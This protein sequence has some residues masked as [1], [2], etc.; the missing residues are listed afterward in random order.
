MNKSNISLSSSRAKNDEYLLKKF[1]EKNPQIKFSGNK[2]Q[3]RSSVSQDKNS[4]LAKAVLSIK[5]MSPKDVALEK[6]KIKNPGIQLNPK[7]SLKKLSSDEIVLNKFKQKNPEIK[8]SLPKV[9]VVKMKLDK[10]QKDMS[11]EDEDSQSDMLKTMYYNPSHPAGYSSPAK[12][13]KYAKRKDPEITFSEVKKWISNERPYYLSKKVYKFP[14]RKVLVR[15]VQHQYQADLMDFVSIKNHNYGFR[16]VLTVIDCFSRKAFAIPLRN[17]KG[18]LVARGLKKA[19]D[20][21][22]VPKKLQTDQGTEFFNKEVKELLDENKIIHFFTR[23][24]LKAQM[25]E[26]FNRTLREKISKHIFASKNLRFYDDIEKFVESYNNS[27][28][29]SL[30]RFT[31]N[32][33]NKLNEDEVRKI[34]YGDY[35]KKKKIHKYKIGDKVRAIIK[36]PFFKKMDK[37]FHDKEFVVTDRVKSFPPTYQIKRADNNT[38]V[39]GVFYEK[40]LQKIL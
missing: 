38:A 40:Q 23:Q 19:F 29:S 24:E 21:L 8:I 31:P 27:V 7:V 39:K 35:L 32:Q 17:K 20:S 33:V 13:Y 4:D 22:G 12:L 34:L 3:T 28:H 37:Q 2:V 1:L 36:R 15:G 16:Y 25:V 10:L 6:F 11:Q 18:F 30:K 5:P 26:R 14:R 9:S